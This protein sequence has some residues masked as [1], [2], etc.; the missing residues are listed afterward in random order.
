VPGFRHLED[1]EVAELARLRVV[2]AS[3]EAPDGTTFERDVIRNL[4]VVAMVPVHPD[5][6]VSL[7]RQY[8][9]PI[10]AELL[11]IPAG[12]CDVPG[13]PPEQTAA[14]ELREELGLAA[15]T[16]ELA[17]AYYPV[18]GFADQFVRL[19]LATGLTHGDAARQGV[20][21]QYMT[22]ERVALADTVAL[23]AEGHI[24][25]SK[26]IIGLLLARDR[27]AGTR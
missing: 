22:E 5:G 4:D 25:D 2:R 6:T 23:V 10:D 7:V 18:A 21:E 27:L 14:R 13:E 15:E 17:A 9:G 1:R 24:R 8:R 11:E 12:L 26:T 3:F 20:E 19:Y 16:L